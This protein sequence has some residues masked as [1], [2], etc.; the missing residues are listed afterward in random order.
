[1]ADFNPAIECGQN[2]SKTDCQICFFKK[3]GK[4]KQYIRETYFKDDKW[5]EKTVL[6][7]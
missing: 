4:A 2:T 7:R 6:C 1:M 3:K 5:M